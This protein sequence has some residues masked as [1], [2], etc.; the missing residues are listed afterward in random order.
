M[1]DST[2]DTFV[3]GVATEFVPVVLALDRAVAAGAD[4]DTRISYQMLTYAVA[5]DFRHWICAI[6]VSKKA[7][8]LRFLFGS[9]LNDPAGRFRAG[10]SPILRTLD[11]ASVEEVDEQ[12]VT[13]YVRDAVSHLDYFR[14]RAL[15]LQEKE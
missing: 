5:G 3:Q 6:G 12:M 1:S 8:N 13:D 11:F 7:V 10:T 2:R 9:L 15:G 4:L 14:A